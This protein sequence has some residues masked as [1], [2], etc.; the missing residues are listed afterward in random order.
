MLPIC[1]H[2]IDWR[3]AAGNLQIGV[4]ALQGD[5]REHIRLL[6]AAGANAVE[7]RTAQQLAEVAG[8]VIPGGESTTIG[9]L[10][11]SFDL[12]DAIRARIESGM[13]VLGTCAGL[14][15][16]ANRVI[17][18]AE[19]Q[20]L[21]GGLPVTVERNAYGS[22]LD[23]FELEIE[24]AAGAERVAFIRAPKIRSVDDP[25]VEVLSALNGEP[26]AVRYRNL[27]GAAFHPELT[28]S[29]WLHRVFLQAATS[30]MAR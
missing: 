30:A 16:L 28:G 15:L 29:Q 17:G 14:I 27:F 25:A 7:V 4:L 13:P 12:L 26:V 8:L 20:T 3:S 2:L 10:L 23:S 22:Q 19:Q 1:P 24:T 5:F 21:I 6:Q 18:A 11:V 9:K